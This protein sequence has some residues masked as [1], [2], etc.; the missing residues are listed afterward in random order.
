MEHFSGAW[1]V[2]RQI[3]QDFQGHLLPQLL[4][5]YPQVFLL[6]GLGYFLHFLPPVAEKKLEKGLQLM[7]LWASVSVMVIFLWFL[8][9][10]KTLEPMIPIYLQF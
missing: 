9:E 2:L 7:P 5:A 1:T 3:T 10:V 6:M 4:G 8:N